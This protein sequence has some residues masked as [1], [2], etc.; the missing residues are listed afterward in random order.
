MNPIKAQSSR[1]ISIWLA[2]AVFALCAMPV[3]LAGEIGRVEVDGRMIILMDDNSWQYATGASASSNNSCKDVS[4]KVLP[5]SVCLNE[6]VWGFA[7]LGGNAEIKLKVNVQ[8]LYLLVITEKTV[9]ALPDLKKAAIANAQSASGPTEVETIEDGSAVIDGH[10]FGRLVYTT[11]VNGID[12]T[13]ANYYTS[14]PAKGSLQLVFF[15][16]A[17]QFPD[18]QE[19]IGEAVSAVTVGK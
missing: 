16:G 7:S 9:I 14:F 18:M 1:L 4:S 3:A 12:I 17:D 13:Y 6:D 8:E 11:T 15:A 19:L 2:A 5:V 10:T